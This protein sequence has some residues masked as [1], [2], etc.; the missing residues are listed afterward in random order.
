VVG[1]SKASSKQKKEMGNRKIEITRR[2]G[3]FDKL[4]PSSRLRR[5][6]RAGQL[7]V[8]ILFFA[9]LSIVLITGFVFLATS[10]LQLSVRAFNR[11]QA[12]SIAESGLEYYRWH[13]AHAPSDYQDGTGGAGPYTHIFYD[14]NGTPIGRF[15]LEITPPAASST[16]VTIRSTGKVDA[17]DTVTKV[18]EVKLGMLSFAQYAFALNSDLQIGSGTEVFGQMMT[19]GGIRFDGLAHNIV[20]SAKYSYNDPTHGGQDEYAVHTHF[21]STDPLPPTA[22]PSR[23]DVFM[24]GRQV[25]VPALDF[26]GVT[27]NL[28]DIKT[29]A[30]NG[31]LYV[32]SS[33]AYGYDL[34]FNSDGTYNLYKVTAL[35]SPPSGCT[36]TSHQDDWGTWSI[37]TETPVSSGPIP[38]NQTFFAED[39]LWVRGQIND[40]RIT[41]ASAKF[42]DNSSTRTSIIVNN[43][44]LYSH[45]DGT[46]AISLI[47][48]KNI[49]V[50]LNSED[51]LRVD[52][53]LFAQNGRVFR[54]F[55]QPPSQHAGS[56][57]CAPNDTRQKITIYG[58][59]VS[60]QPYELG[61]DDGTGYQTRWIIFDENM[62]YNPPP[63]FP[64]TSSDYVQL[65][66]DEIQ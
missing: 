44:L 32:A 4:P 12:F 6:S 55:F 53:A 42:P 62:L 3:P 50:G 19:N 20:K 54:P 7:S 51:I 47:A 26:S 9:A 39:F 21:S 60:N 56:D 16:V 14:K 34:V 36:N 5:A 59:L 27:Q 28:A 10:F 13:L 37:Q 65:S 41:V 46:D 58:A 18:I 64:L 17:D 48:Q 1:S 25:S 8:E 57:K 15:I 40:A 33:G 11:T 30:Q 66:W 63:G 49:I 2:E 24:A 23:P 52:A 61:F 29:K 35:V 22:L 45:Y 31:G 38:S 43:N